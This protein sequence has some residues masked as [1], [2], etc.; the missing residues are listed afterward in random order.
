MKIESFLAYNGIYL[1]FCLPILTT[2]YSIFRFGLKSKI[3]SWVDLLFL[4]G[5]FLYWLLYETRTYFP[6]SSGKTLSNAI[7]EPFYIAIIAAV[8]F[9]TRSLLSKRYPSKSEFIITVTLLALLVC[10][11]AVFFLTP[12]LPE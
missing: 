5:G 2:I 7:G 4:S 12:S 11:L 6:S 3:H 1:L 10:T 9:L 8:L